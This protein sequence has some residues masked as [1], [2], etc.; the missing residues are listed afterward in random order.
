[1][2]KI[3]MFA[4]MIACSVMGAMAQETTQKD[5]VFVVKDGSVVGAYEISDGDYV[6]FSRPIEWKTVVSEAPT[7]YYYNQ[8]YT[9][10]YAYKTTI[11]QYGTTNYFYVDNFLNSGS[12]FTFKLKNTDGS[13]PDEIADINTFD[14]YISP[15][16]DEGVDVT[17]NGTFT[18]CYFYTNN[19]WGWTD[20]AN[21]VTYDY[22][23]FYADSDYAT[24]SG[25][26]KYIEIMCY[27]TIGGKG[28]YSELYI[29]WR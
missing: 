28:Q 21:G 29:D 6:T 12:G 23:Y 20:E 2:K 7:Y 5:S 10:D 25:T 14:G 27:P 16:A 9:W 24:F 13:T 17:D 18:G 22:W 3:A 1:M 19:A 26:G 8:A 15:V 11:Q 4:A